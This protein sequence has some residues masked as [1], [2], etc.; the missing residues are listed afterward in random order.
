MTPS[1]SHLLYC[2]PALCL[3][4]NLPLWILS[5]NEHLLVSW[6]FSYL[7]CSCPRV[8]I[9]GTGR[10][11][12]CWPYIADTSSMQ[13]SVQSLWTTQGLPLTSPWPWPIP[14]NSYRYTRHGEANHKVWQRKCCWAIWTSRE[15]QNSIFQCLLALIIPSFMR[16]LDKTFNSLTSSWMTFWNGCFPIEVSWEASQSQIEGSHPLPHCT[17]T[18]LAHLW[19]REAFKVGWTWEDNL[20]YV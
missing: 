1:L 9:W 17:W 4:I 11:T 15:G 5:P 14:P 8:K 6:G 20:V 10:Q 7:P 19:D 13:S 3:C 12:C 16:S 18:L 2:F